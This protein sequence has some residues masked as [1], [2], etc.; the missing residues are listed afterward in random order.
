M[1]KYIV[2][3]V[4]FITL[5]SALLLTSACSKSN[6]GSPAIS[7]SSGGSGSTSSS[8]SSSGAPIIDLDLENV[9]VHFPPTVATSQGENIVVRG[10]VEDAGTVAQVFINGVAVS[11]DDSLATWKTEV[12]LDVGVN[13]LLVTQQ[14]SDGNLTDVATLTI[15][16]EALFITPTNILLDSANNRLLVLDKSLNAIIAADRTTGVKSFLSPTS[17]DDTNLIDTPYGVVLDATR[18][19]TLVHFNTPADSEEKED[20]PKPGIVAVDLSTGEQSV[21]DFAPVEGTNSL[22]NRPALLM[23]NESD[24]YIADTEV[25]YFTIVDEEA[26]RVPA[27]TEDSYE[28]LSGIIFHVDLTTNIQTI[29]S[30]YG[31]P[32]EEFSIGN[33]T[34]MA[35]DPRSPLIYA[36]DFIDNADGGTYRLYSLDKATGKAALIEY[37]DEGEE[38]EEEDL[39]FKAFYTYSM[40]FDYDNQKL[41]FLSKDV[42]INLDI[43]SGEYEVIASPI[44]PED[45]DYPIRKA[46]SMVANELGDKL[47]LVDNA[48]DTV[49][50]IDIATGLR[51]RV[52]STAPFDDKEGLLSSFAPRD[53][54]L[55]IKNNRILMPNVLAGSILSYDLSTGEKTLP[56]TSKDIEDPENTD[57]LKFPLYSTLNHNT[58]E[59]LVLDNLNQAPNISLLEDIAQLQAANVDTQEV[60]SLLISPNTGTVFNDITFDHNTNIAYISER[61]LVSNIYLISKIDL[62]KSEPVH[63]NFSYIGRPSFDYPFSVLTSLAVDFER[64]RLLVLDTKQNAI[65]DVSL[66]DGYRSQ[67]SNSGLP[68][69]GGP[70]LAQPQAIV[71]DYKRNRALVL[72]SVLNAIIAVDLDTGVREVVIENITTSTTKLFNPKDLDIHP[73]F[74]YVVVIDNTTSTTMAFD[75]LTNERVT[76]TR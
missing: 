74:D 9:Q 49:L 16:R 38:E 63:E 10:I 36:V 6:S 39:T 32:D 18:N 7:S 68:K 28:L 53:L 44:F 56:I 52:A 45:S 60:T 27:G 61:N 1:C 37:G 17:A 42:I 72:D 13:T 21:V 41:L 48:L 31:T 30:S 26:V 20:P 12:S 64:N 73:V 5:I 3:P 76:L 35:T 8:S 47:Y 15:S 67:F 34:A 14:D 71:I 50:N 69:N 55:D 11:S 19:R 46:E 24:L 43:A 54:T 2:K 51:S 57:Y 40:H 25:L 33:I 58:G 23:D 70:E 62:S 65:I 4:A 22:N 75:L 66:H 29:F 59:L